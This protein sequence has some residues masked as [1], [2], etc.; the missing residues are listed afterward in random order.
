MA[1]RHQAHEEQEKAEGL[2]IVATSISMAMGFTGHRIGD[3]RRT[4]DG[5][6]PCGERKKESC[7]ES[8]GGFVEKETRS[9]QRMATISKAEISWEKLARSNG[10]K[11]DHQCRLLKR[12]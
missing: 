6:Y 3:K 11:G 4:Y 2:S 10:T 7:W 8:T 1:R 12:C 9:M 5:W